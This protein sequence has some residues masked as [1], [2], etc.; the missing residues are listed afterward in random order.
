MYFNELVYYFEIP[1]SDFY[2]KR[3]LGSINMGNPMY[4]YVNWRK[5]KT[6]GWQVV[7]QRDEKRYLL[8]AADQWTD[9][10]LRFVLIRQGY[11]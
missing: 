5:N 6:R 3:H 10:V 2:V 4:T 1:V 7:Y 8:L 11:V 9:A